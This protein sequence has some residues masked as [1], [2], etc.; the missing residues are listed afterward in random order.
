MTFLLDTCHAVCVG[1]RALKV[2]KAACVWYHNRFSSL[3]SLSWLLCS[4]PV[5]RKSRVC[6]VG[7]VG[8]LH[9]LAAAN[10]ALF[11]QP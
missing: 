4:V 11:P 8:W 3:M 10:Y 1:H 2:L 9:S 7:K 5:S 6:K